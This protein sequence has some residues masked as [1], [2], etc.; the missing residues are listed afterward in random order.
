VVRAARTSKERRAAAV[1]RVLAGESTP[2]QEARKLRV[3]VAALRGFVTKQTREA[4]GSPERSSA[5]L[6]PSNGSQKQPS[7]AATSRRSTEPTEPAS[8]NSS[9]PS[10]STLPPSTS[11]ATDPAP[12]T[13]DDDPPAALD[14]ALHGAGLTGETVA[15]VVVAPPTPAQL[16]EQVE[17]LK[18]LLVGTLADAS[19]VRLTKAQADTLCSFTEAERRN[20]EQLA[21]FAAQ[22]VPKLL[23]ADPRYAAGA[24][25]VLFGWSVWSSVKELK[26]MA[27]VQRATD[28]ATAPPAS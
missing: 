20:L 24:F 7:S 8:Y 6:P 22:Y 14:D 19:K 18:G 1:D 5:P 11:A 10:S 23:G 16:V 28:T 26:R 3:S 15:V 12:S 9:S 13:A 4:S 2:E 21:P 17:A 25:V 27:R